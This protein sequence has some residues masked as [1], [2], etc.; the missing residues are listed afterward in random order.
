[1]NGA[2]LTPTVASVPL[3]N[4]AKILLDFVLSFWENTCVANGSKGDE[5]FPA[6]ESVNK[7]AVQV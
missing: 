6:N 1:M 7:A 2:G 3:M 5:H 4:H